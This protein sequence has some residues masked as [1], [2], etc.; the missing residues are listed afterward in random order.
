MKIA[1]FNHGLREPAKRIHC[2]STESEDV[3]IISRKWPTQGWVQ[4]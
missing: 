3:G 4:L 2:E 1:F